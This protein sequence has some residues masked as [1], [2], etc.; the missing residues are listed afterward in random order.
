[1]QVELSSTDFFQIVGIAPRTRF[2]G[3]PS[4]W[5][6]LSKQS[7]AKW[8]EQILKSPFGLKLAR[9][10]LTKAF[11]VATSLEDFGLCKEIPARGFDLLL[12]SCTTQRQAGIFAWS[13]LSS[14]EQKKKFPSFPRVELSIPLCSRIFDDKMTSKA[15]STQSSKS[16]PDVFCL[17]NGGR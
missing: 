6:C 10:I 15:T 14:A 9:C 5:T 2:L 3:C 1:M 4:I 7:A 11:H 8:I 17:S 12:Q 13:E 16:W